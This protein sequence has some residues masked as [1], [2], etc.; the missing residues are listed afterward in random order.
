MW[1]LLRNLVLA[2]VLLA[3]ILKLLAWYV[4]GQVVQR[5][6][7]A[8]E[9]YAQ[10]QYEGL[11]AGLDGSVGLSGVRVA[12]KGAH[13][14]YRADY[15]IIDSPGLLWLLRHA[16]THDTT[17]PAQLGITAT[18]LNLPP[19]PWLNPQ[20]LDPIRFTLFSSAGCPSPLGAA[21]F[22]RMGIHTTA[23]AQERFA[24]H[25]NPDRHTLDATLSVSAPGFAALAL[26][27]QLSR[28]DT[29]TSLT[30]GFLDKVHVDQ[31][32]ASYTD[33]GFARQRTRYCAAA[34][35]STP[36]QFADRHIAAVRAL[37]QQERIQPGDE[38]QR[39]YRTLV[40][41][42]GQ[43]SALSLPNPGFTPGEWDAT[44]RDDL[45][46]QLNVTARYQDRPPVMLRLAFSPAPAVV[47]PD[48]SPRSL[49]TAAPTPVSAQPEPPPAPVATRPPI[50]VAPAPGVVARA[51]PPSGTPVATTGKPAPM[52]AATHAPNPATKISPPPTRIA[53]APNYL[54]RAEARLPQP[55]TPEAPSISAPEIRAAPL[56][57]L[58][59]SAS[60]PTSAELALI[61]KP[62]LIEP[63]PETAP[64]KRNYNVVDF[65]SLPELTGR[66]VRLITLGGKDIEGFVLSADANGVQVRV[67]RAGGDAVFALARNRVTQVQLL[68]W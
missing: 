48:V 16:L 28:F 5:T 52:P 15:A 22:Q 34:E 4:A 31:L 35:H 44:S 21:D 67:T 13:R 43:M 2:A 56:A 14:I 42:G 49:A 12:P 19:E 41:Q 32:S 24:Y 40:L 3:G 33:L 27:A 37:L 30:R 47:P 53:E 60:G 23:P 58:A 46:R 63:L 18:G 68:H 10:I 29:A 54:D 11:T 1:K 17:L 39:L 57:P 25:Y 55:P 36:A 66:H 62:G 65:S 59:S 6:V 7:V 50:A 51:T 38:V 9:P 45:L 26:E 61:W 8:L 64:P 20:W